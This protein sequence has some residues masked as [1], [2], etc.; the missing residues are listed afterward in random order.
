MP[1]GDNT[2]NQGYRCQC[3]DGY[4]QRQGV[5]RRCIDYCQAGFN[6]CDKTTTQCIPTPGIGPNYRCDCTSSGHLKQGY[7]QC[8]G[9]QPAQEVTSSTCKY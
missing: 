9:P 2:N 6:Y 7:Y 4:G 1:S 3:R 5:D 8:V